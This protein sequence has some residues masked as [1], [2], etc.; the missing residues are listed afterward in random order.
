MS[1]QQNDDCDKK[2]LDLSSLNNA[3]YNQ[4]LIVEGFLSL[5]LAIPVSDGIFS[6][7][8]ARWR[9]LKQFFVGFLSVKSTDG[10]R[11]KR[12]GKFPDTFLSAV[13][14]SHRP[15]LK[16]FSH[17]NIYFFGETKSWSIF[18]SFCSKF[19]VFIEV[20]IVLIRNL[21]S[22]NFLKNGRHKKSLF[23]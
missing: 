12:D 3:R 9:I 18:N 2:L 22:T 23:S 7:I 15:L 13:V 16:S 4:V 19:F 20:I 5:L 14:C 1:W 6:G 17:K 8:W 10:T 21:I 11:E